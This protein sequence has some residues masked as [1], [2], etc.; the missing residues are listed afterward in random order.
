M[1][2]IGGE[3]VRAGGDRGHQN[4]PSEP[5]KHRPC[6]LKE[7]E[8]A[9][10]G[11]S[12]VPSPPRTSHPNHSIPLS[13]PRGPVAI[14]QSRIYAPTSKPPDFYSHNSG[15]KSKLLSET[16]SNLLIITPPPVK[17]KSKLC[18]SNM[19]WHRIYIIVPKGRTGGHN[20]EVLDQSKTKNQQSDA[21]S[22]TSMSSVKRLSWL[23]HSS[24]VDHSTLLP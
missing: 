15:S 13:G 9:C 12:Q 18:T 8:A 16:Q 17:P 24:F 4:S 6:E 21:K 1:E 20:E 22:Y 10:T 7:A 14:S 5:T 3:H 11:S 19:K 2:E 23:C